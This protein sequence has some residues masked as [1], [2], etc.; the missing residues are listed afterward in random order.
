MIA[1]FSL[2]RQ[3]AN[4]KSTSQ[5]K[6][7]CNT[8]LGRSE[9]RLNGDYVQLR[10]SVLVVEPDFLEVDIIKLCVGFKVIKQ[11]QNVLIDITG[12]GSID[13]DFGVGFDRSELFLKVAFAH[14]ENTLWQI[15]VIDFFAI[16]F[17]RFNPLILE[18]S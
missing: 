5:L 6:V 18:P 10:R 16:D 2:K 14:E 12:F 15:H 17:L 11:I 7:A 3:V 9:S 4:N 1:L 13:N 8:H